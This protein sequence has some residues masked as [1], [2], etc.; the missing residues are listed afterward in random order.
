MSGCFK[1]STLPP[2]PFATERH[3][4][5]L[6]YSFIK[7]S[8]HF[9]NNTAADQR[10][11]KKEKKKRLLIATAKQSD[12]CSLQSSMGIFCSPSTCR[13]LEESCYLGVIK[14]AIPYS[15]PCVLL[16]LMAA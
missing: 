7:G 9:I 8:I 16:S 12:V 4:L 15:L 2:Q 1:R 5:S 6:F 3:S 13:K 10:W 11:G 14:E